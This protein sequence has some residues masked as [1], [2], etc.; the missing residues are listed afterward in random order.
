VQ[1]NNFSH[2]LT[3]VIPAFNEE[4]AIGGTVSA[5]LEAVTQIKQ[6]SGVRDVELIVVSDGSTDRTA[7]I[8]RSFENVKLIEFAQN[9]GYGAALMEGFRHGSGSLVSFLDADGTCDPR[10]FGELARTAIEENADVVLGSRL[11]PESQMPRVRRIGNHLFAILLGLLCGKSITDTAS[12]M[13]VIRRQALDWL[14][15]LPTGLHFTPSMSARALLGGLRLVEVP[16]PYAERI[17]QSKLR[18]VSDGL[19]FTRVILHDVLCYRPERL[20]LMAFAVCLIVAVSLAAYPVE[21]YASHQCVE[22]WMIYRFLV[23]GLLGSAGYQLLIGT[24]LAHR[25]ARFGPQ[26]HV[27]DSFWPVMV[28]KLFEGWM[29]VGFVAVLTVVSLVILWPG[30]IEYAMTR[31]VHMHWS[32]LVV[33]TF[34]LVV[35]AQ[36]TVAGVLMRVLEIWKGQAGP[37]GRARTE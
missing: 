11:G 13:R 3:I 16:M 10:I 14:Y 12:G 24:A 18:I 25:M 28:A 32:R 22:E 30:L 37:R 34:G 4:E 5:C 31:H 19:R 9:R 33:G 23:C 17:G 15:P 2:T 1:P 36:G 26:R 29:I 21:Y 20:F 6:E 27:S 35:A 8:V 7:A